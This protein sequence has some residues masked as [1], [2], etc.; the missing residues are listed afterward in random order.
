MISTSYPKLFSEN[1]HSE[2]I[3]NSGIPLAGSRKAKKCINTKPWTQTGSRAPVINYGEDENVLYNV[4]RLPDAEI[5]SYEKPEKIVKLNK[6]G[7]EIAVDRRV[8]LFFQQAILCY[9]M[10]M[11]RFGA[12]AAVD[13]IGVSPKMTLKSESGVKVV[14]KREAAHSSTLPTLIAYP[15]DGSMPQGFVYLAGGSSYSQHNSTIGMHECVNGA[16][17]LIDGKGSDNKLRQKAVAILNLVADGLDPVKATRQF[18]DA[19]KE[20]VRTEGKRL[21]ISDPR[22]HV[23]REYFRNIHHIKG[24]TQS[25]ELFDRLIGLQIGNGEGEK[26]RKLRKV[27]Y[28]RRFDIIRH[29]EVAECRIARRIEETQKVMTAREKSFLEEMLLKEFSEDNTRTILEKLLSKSAAYNDASYKQTLDAKD[30]RAYQQR[31]TR[32]Q[33]LVQKYHHEIDSLKRDLRR[34]FRRLAQ[35]ELIYRS[36]V[37]WTL[38]KEVCGWTQKEFCKQ[39][40]Q[41]SGKSVSQSWVSRMEHGSHL[42]RRPEEEYRTPLNQ[43]RR[44]VSL[45]DARACASTFG[46]DAGLFLPGLFTS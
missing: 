9:K 44:Y 37:F 46:V 25:S 7:I 36:G 40:E 21:D 38:R 13:Q 35:D 28:K 45:S 39:H 33:N 17:E 4:N 30:K 5:R 16:D 42:A 22:R 31:Q 6:E 15:K 2:E 18:L 41:K 34:E 26:E 3:K 11:F 19:F 23:L 14:H 1:S 24:A 8:A 12:S 27:V 43:R 20:Q 29:Q 32:I 10:S